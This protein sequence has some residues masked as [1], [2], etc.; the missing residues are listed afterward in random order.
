R[1]TWVRYLAKRAACRTGFSLISPERTTSRHSSSSR[2]TPSTVGSAATKA[3]LSEPML[4]PTT[5]SG[6]MSAA[7]NACSMPTWVAPKTPPPPRTKAVM[8]MGARLLRRGVG[9]RVGPVQGDDVHADLEA[10]ATPF[11]EDHSL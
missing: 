1:M 6:V 5:R 9:A 4:V 7:S 11:A 2:A 3:P 10:G 8:G